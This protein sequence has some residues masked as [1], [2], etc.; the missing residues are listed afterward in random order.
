MRIAV[1]AHV[2][3]PIAPPFKGGM[4][5]HSWHLVRGLLAR[6]HDVTLLASGDSDPGLPVQPIAPLHYE[7]T[8]PWAQFRG[9]PQLDAHLDRTFGNAAAL[10]ASGDFDAVHYNALH[11]HLLHWASTNRV[12][13][14]ATLH[15]PPFA[16]LA[17]AVRDSEAP[18]ILKTVVSRK[19]LS[20]WFP[21]GHPGTAHVLPNGIDL[22]AWRFSPAGDGSAVWAGRIMANKG[23]GEAA[24]AAR[25][26]GMPLRIHGVIEDREYFETQV[27]PHLDGRV[28]YEGHAGP[29]ALA[30]S[31]GRAS[32]M[33]FTPLWDE[34]FGLS[35]VEALACG[36]PVATFE[37]GAVREVLGDHA[38]YAPSGDVPALAQAALQAMTL[39]RAAC[40]AHVAEQYT[41]ETMIERAE[42]LYRK[43][44]AAIGIA[45]REGALT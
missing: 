1:V 12:P 13:L 38:T 44:A 30:D 33:L 32:V 34:P 41:L 43:A 11:P 2:R 27:A 35:A 3:H 7:A 6:G 42:S 10:I 37:N 14:V 16:L 21:G 26:A 28:T 22:D 40:R 17:N 15:V 19:Q 31:V 25:L 36:T 5:A 9:T 39:D 4:E 20:R 45:A 18:W 24:R 23:T 8:L 29:G